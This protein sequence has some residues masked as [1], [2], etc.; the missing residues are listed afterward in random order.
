MEEER[1]KMLAQQKEENEKRDKE[2]IE[3]DK[4]HQ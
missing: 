2:R 4:K 1:I 3:A